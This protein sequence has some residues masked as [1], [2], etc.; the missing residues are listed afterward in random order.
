MDALPP[1]YRSVMQSWF[2]LSLRVDNGEIVIDGAKS[3]CAL[4]SLTARFV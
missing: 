3:S 2:S 4:H 1:F